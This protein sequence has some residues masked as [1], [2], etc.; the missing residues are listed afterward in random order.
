MFTYTPYI[1]ICVFTIA[2]LAQLVISVFMTVT[3]TF[4]IRSSEVA[5]D[6]EGYNET[7]SLPLDKTVALACGNLVG[8][9]LKVF[10]EQFVYLYAYVRVNNTVF[11]TISIQATAQL[12]V[13]KEAVGLTR[14]HMYE[15]EYGV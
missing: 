4:A 11:N 2:S 9:A 15:S 10:R 7:I 3:F 14:I 13:D 1:Y 6:E 8:N 12:D 5:L